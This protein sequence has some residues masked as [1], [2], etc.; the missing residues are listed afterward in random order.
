MAG[1]IHTWS[2]IEDQHGNHITQHFKAAEA[3]VTADISADGRHK[4][5][6]Q[7]IQDDISI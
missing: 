3:H 1:R 7:R 5:W 2:G 4:R 6:H